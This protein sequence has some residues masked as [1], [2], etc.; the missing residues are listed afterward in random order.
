MVPDETSYVKRHVEALLGLAQI[1]PADEV[2]ELGCGMGRHTLPLAR[3]GLRVTGLDLSPGLLEKLRA[4]N[5]GQ[6]EIP[7]Y[8]GDILQP[9]EALLGRFDAVIG[10]FTLH[11]LYDLDASFAG[12]TRL[13][14]PEGR[15]VFLEPNA[16]NPL[17]YLQILLTPGM[18]WEG[19][20]GMVRMRP[21]YVKRSMRNAGL[22]DLTIQ[23]LGFFPPLLANRP[24]GQRLERFL[25]RNPLWRPLL[26]FQL[27]KGVWR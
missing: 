24:W 15:I 26:P 16:F 7:L 3:R 21:G 22:T 14:K 1:T 19:D 12:M 18:T 11:H 23:R 25:E 4:Y 9:P 10:F 8:A 13:L 20:G 6:F 27:F 2:L 5:D 17:Y